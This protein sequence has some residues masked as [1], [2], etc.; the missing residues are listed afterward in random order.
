MGVAL[1]ET[2]FCAV[3]QVPGGR[4]LCVHRDD[5][6]LAE[7]LIDQA[8][9]R[10]WSCPPTRRGS[11]VCR[12]PCPAAPRR[13]PR[14][15]LP[16]STVPGARPPPARGS[17]MALLRR[18]RRSPNPGRRHP[19]PPPVP[20]RVVPLPRLACRL[21]RRELPLRHRQLRTRRQGRELRL[22][23]AL[24]PRQVIR[25]QVRQRRR[26]LLDL[27]RDGVSIRQ[28][29][30]RVRAASS[31]VLNTSG[32]RSRSSMDGGSASLLSHQPLSEP[33]G[34]RSRHRDGAAPSS[35]VADRQPLGRPQAP[36]EVWSADLVFDRT[37]EGR[38]V[39]CLTI[40][41]DATTDAVAIVPA[42]PS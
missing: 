25:P 30:N 22:W 24:R 12:R 14:F 1:W 17:P 13:R 18:H 11:S 36:N 10:P 37:V 2:A 33:C 7:Q 38:V 8:G 29:S 3:F 21:I 23:H 15:A 41:D 42:F 9:A 5:R 40:V 4:V 27:L 16:V 32:C 28:R 39:K 19:P 31:V 26:R 35:R 6:A 20:L 34:L